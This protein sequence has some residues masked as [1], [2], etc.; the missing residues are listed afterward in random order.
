MFYDQGIPF[1]VFLFLAIF[2]VPWTFEMCYT[3]YTIR[4]RNGDKI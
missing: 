1:E 3:I 2:N 4:I